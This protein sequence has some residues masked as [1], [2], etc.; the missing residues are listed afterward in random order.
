MPF[1]GCRQCFEGGLPTAIFACDRTGL[2]LLKLNCHSRPGR[3]VAKES[4]GLCALQH[5]VV[6]E[7]LRQLEFRCAEQR[8]CECEQE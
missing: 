4:N 8:L 2:P 1:S 3:R 6:G 7:Q 5:H